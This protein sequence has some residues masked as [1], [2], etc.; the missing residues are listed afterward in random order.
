MLERVR[1][2]S[3]VE[4]MLLRPRHQQ[5]RFYEGTFTMPCLSYG[6]VLATGVHP[7]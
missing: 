4:G 7:M 5:Q 2:S 1:E 6:A 3:R